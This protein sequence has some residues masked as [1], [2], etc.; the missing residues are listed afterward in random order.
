MDAQLQ[1]QIDQLQAQHDA[2]AAEVL[3]KDGS[4]PKKNAPADQVEQL[5][6]IADALEQ[7]RAMA[8]QAD[9]GPTDPD[10]DDAEHLSEQAQ[11]GDQQPAPLPL[12]GETPAGSD[13]SAEPQV[14]PGAAGGDE[15]APP[16]TTATFKDELGKVEHALLTL[17]GDLADV[18]QHPA[19][20]D[21][22]AMGAA[23]RLQ[24][25]AD[26]IDTACVHIR[27]VRDQLQLRAEGRLRRWR[28]QGQVPLRTDG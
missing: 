10:T 15:K 21:N 7:A 1:D 20:M 28:E 27:S 4:R 14:A 9:A 24:Q 13:T 17:V 16:F 22:E 3:I 26:T 5:E 6:R 12:I 23:S 19:F 25:A 11:Q 18:G 8:A 2:L